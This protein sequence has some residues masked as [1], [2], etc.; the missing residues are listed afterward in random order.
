MPPVLYLVFGGH[1]M[2]SLLSWQPR[3]GWKWEDLE[4]VEDITK[5]LNRTQ[6]M[7][8]AVHG[9]HLKSLFF[10]LLTKEGGVALSDDTQSTEKSQENYQLTVRKLHSAQN[11]WLLMLIVC[12][13]SLMQCVLMDSCN[14]HK[15]HSL[16]ARENCYHNDGVCRTFLQ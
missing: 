12:V 8:V 15:N 13:Y 3:N 11:S 4:I 1:F 6:I 9:W 7:D 10:P 5:V 2:P 14:F 16:T